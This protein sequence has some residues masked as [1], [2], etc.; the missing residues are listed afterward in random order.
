M[1]RP[2]SKKFRIQLQTIKI[3]EKQEEKETKYEFLSFL[4]IR[5]QKNGSTELID[6]YQYRGGKE[7]HINSPENSIV[8][9]QWFLDN[10]TVF[11]EWAF[12]S[13][14]HL[15]RCFSPYYFTGELFKLSLIYRKKYL[16]A[17]LSHCQ[18]DFFE[19]QAVLSLH[20]V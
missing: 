13:F 14:I 15:S 12:R 18:M 20:M 4:R 3:M 5:P 16:I 7:L 10:C 19:E 1:K 9:K 11:Q 6:S 2:N 8:G 17:Q